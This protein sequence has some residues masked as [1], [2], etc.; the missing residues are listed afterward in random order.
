M[1]ERRS[2]CKAEADPLPSVE[3]ATVMLHHTDCT[4]QFQCIPSQSQHIQA[5]LSSSQR[6]EQSLHGQPGIMLGFSLS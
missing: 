4:E 6:P 1:N 5:S 2:S 3:S